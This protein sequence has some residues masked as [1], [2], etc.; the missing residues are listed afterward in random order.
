MKSCMACN[1]YIDSLIIALVVIMLPM[2]I[3]LKFA[4]YREHS[5]RIGYEIDV[6]MPL[7]NFRAVYKAGP[8]DLTLSRHS[9]VIHDA[10]K[11][12][13]TLT[14]LIRITPYYR[15]Q[16]ADWKALQERPFAGQAFRK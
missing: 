16:E 5:Q 3:C 14:G 9:V 2:A 6:M 7:D 8:D 12:D 15:G 13:M 4:E 11:T 10:H 1:H